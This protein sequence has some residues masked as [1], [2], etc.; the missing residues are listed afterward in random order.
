M[1]QVGSIALPS[2]Q[3]VDS[4][5]D[6]LRSIKEAISREHGDDVRCVAATLRRIEGANAS[7]VRRPPHPTPREIG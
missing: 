7:R 1:F 2:P 5:F 4:T 6:E 3:R